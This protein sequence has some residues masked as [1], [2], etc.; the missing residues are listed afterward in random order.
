MVIWGIII[1]RQ[2]HIYIAYQY[3]NIHIC[4]LRSVH[5]QRASCFHATNKERYM[6]CCTHA[7]DLLALSMWFTVVPYM[8]CL[9]LFP[10]FLFCHVF[11]QQAD[12][13]VTVMAGQGHW[14]TG[15]FPRGRLWFEPGRFRQ[16][17]VSVAHSNLASVAECRHLFTHIYIPSGYLT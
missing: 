13:E 11:P 9:S 2:N 12:H 3:F 8:L 4:I 6:L 5:W 1:F 14:R 15:T 7:N 10:W 17:V 16:H